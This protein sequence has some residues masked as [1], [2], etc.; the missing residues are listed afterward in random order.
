MY[1]IIKTGIFARYLHTF[2]CGTQGERDC[3][4]NSFEKKK[5][6]LS[7]KSLV[8]YKKKNVYKLVNSINLRSPD[9]DFSL[10]IFTLGA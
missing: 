2:L 4:G 1:F 9:Q 3:K 6:L 5:S 10:F 7:L 8:R